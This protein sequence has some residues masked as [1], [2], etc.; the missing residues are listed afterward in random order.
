MFDVARKDNEEYAL[1]DAEG[2]SNFTHPEKRGETGDENE[3]DKNK[4][5]RKRK[6]VTPI[7]VGSS[8][9]TSSSNPVNQPVN[10]STSRISQLIDQLKTP[11]GNRSH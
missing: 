5:R 3:S 6:K 2:G 4:R 11:E 8:L 9:S 1:V 7:E 10:H